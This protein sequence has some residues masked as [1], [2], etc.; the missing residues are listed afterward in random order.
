M[1]ILL[2][3]AELE[4]KEACKWLRAAGFPQYAQ[5]YEGTVATHRVQYTRVMR[6]ENSVGVIGNYVCLFR[7]TVSHR[8]ERCPKGPSVPGRGLVA[9]V[10]Q[11]AARVEPLRQHEIGF[12][13]KTRR[14]ELRAHR[15]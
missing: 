10:V 15:V 2:F 6:T 9:V 5:M 7:F 1:R 14:G 13:A 11:E 3:V 4:A 8:R 12:R